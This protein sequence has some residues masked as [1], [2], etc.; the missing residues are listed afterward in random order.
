MATIQ[1]IWNDL[2]AGEQTPYVLLDIA[3]FERGY[4][5]LPQAAFASIECLF[6]GDLADELRDVAPYLA[7][8][9]SFD[10]SVRDV[11]AGLMVDQIATLV[12][13]SDPAT[14]FSQ[15]HRHFRKF[16][17]VYSAEGNPLF[18]RYHDP[19]VLLDALKVFDEPQR[20]IFFG[21]AAQFTF[22]AGDPGYVRCQAS[23]AE[24]LLST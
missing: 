6:T 15:L 16:N 3:G 7:R 12:E 22:F 18:F 2:R 10:N 8:A 21:P 1:D 5:Q 9:A 19:R 17:L 23:G 13:L 4:A 24:L 11:L 14:T 20:K